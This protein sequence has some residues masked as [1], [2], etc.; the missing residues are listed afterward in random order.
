MKLSVIIPVYNGGKTLRTCLVA[1]N[2]STHMPDDVIVVDDSSTDGSAAIASSL[3]TRVI[4]LEGGPHG[5]AAARNRGA[6]EAHGDI[7]IFF[8]ADVAVHPDT[9]ALMHKYLNEQPDLAALFGSYDS[10]PT[11]QSVVSRYKNLQ[12]H[13]IHQHAQ[14]ES[15]SFWTGCGAIRSHIFAEVGGFD[16]SYA[17]IEDIELGARLRRAGYRVW[18]CKDIQATHLKEWTLRSMMRTDIF[19][20]A[21]PWARLIFSE[22]HLPQD[23]NLTMGSRVSALAVWAMISFIALGVAF[24]AA[25]IG[26]LIALILLI[27]LNEDLYRFFVNQGGIAFGAC[28][29]GLHALYLV[30][31]S[32]V[33]GGMWAAAKFK[34]PTPKAPT[35]SSANSKI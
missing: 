34:I 25:W 12:H 28:A 11:G 1:L 15:F 29:I 30:Y 26:A 16:G 35:R 14:R 5:A 3:L 27:A 33:F 31:S 20:R 8:D 23:L 32:L 9:V 6:S 7:L 10:Q 18:L 17:A 4:Q 13:Y 2:A 22:S 24:P 21:V 19:D